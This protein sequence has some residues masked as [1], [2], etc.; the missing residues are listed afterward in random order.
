MKNYL[1]KGIP[2][3][4]LRNFK[5]ACAAKGKTMKHVIIEFMIKFSKK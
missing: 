2:Q 4:V 3:E 5:A 1:L